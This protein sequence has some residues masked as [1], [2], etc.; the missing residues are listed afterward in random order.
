MD[1]YLEWLTINVFIFKSFHCTASEKIKGNITPNNLA[2]WLFP[3][4][5]TLIKKILYRI[6]HYLNWYVFWLTVTI[7]L[8]IFKT[9]YCIILEKIKSKITPRNKMHPTTWIISVYSNTHKKFLHRLAYSF[10]YSL[11]Y[12]QWICMQS[13][14]DCQYLLFLIHFTV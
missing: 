9:F 4:I 6:A 8:F 3:Y 12:S 14:P 2:L 13:N 1:M 7:T 5:Q 10:L 11:F